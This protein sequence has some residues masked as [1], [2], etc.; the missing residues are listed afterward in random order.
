MSNR[1]RIGE[2]IKLGFVGT[3]SSTSSQAIGIFDANN[4]VRPLQA[5]ERIAVDMIYVGTSLT[6]GYILSAPAGQSTAYSSTIMGSFGGNNS[7]A[8]AV[9]PNYLG[10]PENELNIPT[11]VVP[12]ILSLNGTGVIALTGVG[13]ILSGKSQSQYP[14]WKA[15]TTPGQTV[16]RNF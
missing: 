16:G 10:I 11:G 4:Q 5:W 2:P 1:S 3:P 9:S 14:T 6:V 15:G 8:S 12:S 13:R 7:T